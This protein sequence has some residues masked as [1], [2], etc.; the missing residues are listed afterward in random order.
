MNKKIITL[1]VA[2]LAFTAACG[3]SPSAPPAASTTGSAT[4]SGQTTTSGASTPSCAE[5]A[6]WGTGPVDV[7]GSTTDA[8]FNTRV[9]QQDCYDRVVFDINGTAP[10]GYAVRYVPVVLADASGMPL[11]VPGGAVL[12]VVVRAPEQ[13]FDQSGHQPW[14]VPPKSGD[15]LV[16][17]AQV[18]SWTSLRAVRFAG[19]F[20]GQCT[21]AVGVRTTLPFRVFTFVDEPNHARRVVLDIAH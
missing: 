13:G 15:Y 12:R 5:T 1:G 16:P 20:E 8:L 14:Q 4:S 11:P 10:V 9:G 3:G 21:F 19:F 2:V 7:A 17:A 6:T 18:A